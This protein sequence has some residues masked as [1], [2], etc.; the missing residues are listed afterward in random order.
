MLAWM[1]LPMA[2]FAQLSVGVSAGYAKNT[3][4]ADPG[5]YYNREYLSRD[6]YAIA[7]PVKYA[8]NDWFA[9]QGELGYTTKNY[10]WQ[11]EI[12]YFAMSEYEEYTNGYLQIPI[13]A[14][15]NFGNERIRGFVNLG[16]YMGAWLNG[17]VE[18]QLCEISYMTL[19]DVEQKYEFN[20]QRDNRFDG[21]LV[22]GLGAQYNVSPLVSIFAEARLVYALSDTQKNYMIDQYHRYNTTSIIQVGV[23]YN[24]SL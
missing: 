21:G 20:S 23:L 12:P 22:A 5:Y 10:A 9:L 19:V 24:F 7:V 13:M 3:I 2:S 1:L 6:G 4:D 18:G 8:F 17:Y 14:H 15:L 11:R 16:A